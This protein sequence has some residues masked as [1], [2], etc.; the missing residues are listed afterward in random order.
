MFAGHVSGQTVLILKT[1]AALA[2]AY[3]LLRDVMR[4]EVLAHVADM[5]C[6][7]VAETALTA[8][9]GQSHR[10]DFEVCVKIL[11]WGRVGGEVSYKQKWALVHCLFKHQV[12]K[13]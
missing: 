3:P 10:V 4:D 1:V 11:R 2:A 5:R 7:F 8:P 9:V 6:H 12:E 13:N